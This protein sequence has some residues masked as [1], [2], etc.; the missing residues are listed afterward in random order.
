[1]RTRC[2]PPPPCKSPDTTG[3]AR[4]LAANENKV[5]V[6]TLMLQL[7]SGAIGLQLPGLRNKAVE[8]LQSKAPGAG[9]TVL[10]Q[11]TGARSAN[12]TVTLPAGQGGTKAGQALLAAISTCR[13]QLGTEKL[14]FGLRLAP[15]PRPSLPPSR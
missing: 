7:P 6:I 8:L 10:V 12:L 2:R 9:W 13:L 1:M 15:P 5:R 11:Q 14:D 3:A 4:S